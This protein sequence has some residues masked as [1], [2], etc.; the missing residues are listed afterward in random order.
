M[1]NVLDDFM[2]GLSNCDKVIVALT[3]VGEREF[4]TKEIYEAID[5]LQQPTLK[6]TTE[7]NID[8]YNELKA[9]ADKCDEKETPYKPT[10]VEHFE[11]DK[12]GFCKCGKAVAENENYCAHC[13]NKLDWH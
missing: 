8:Y 5:K 4:S 9:K 11:F 7:I 2:V 13:G 10:G 1:T 6:P 12:V 3:G